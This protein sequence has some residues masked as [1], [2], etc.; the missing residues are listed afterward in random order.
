M[1]EQELVDDM[2]IG[3]SQSE[4]KILEKLLFRMHVNLQAK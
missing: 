4:Q 2:L 1:K 3:V